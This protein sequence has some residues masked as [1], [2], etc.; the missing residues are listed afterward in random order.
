MKKILLVIIF[1]IL[2]FSIVSAERGR[3]Q[4]VNNNLVAD[5]GWFLRGENSW[6]TSSERNNNSFWDI[7]RDEFNMNIIRVIVYREPQNWGCN[8]DC[9]VYLDCTLD[10]TKSV[11]CGHNCQCP[12]Y[13][14]RC[15]EGSAYDVNCLYT[16]FTNV[17]SASDF[18]INPKDGQLTGTEYTR[19]LNFMNTE[20]IPYLDD[21]VEMS[22]QKNFYLMIDYHP[23]GGNDPMDV[24]LF[25]ELIAPRYKDRTHV[26]Y[27]LM[28]EPSILFTDNYN[29]ANNIG[30]VDLEVEL[31]NLARSLAPETHLI[32]WTFSHVKTASAKPTI[33][34]APEIDYSKASVG[35]HI[36]GLKEIYLDPIKA[37]Y[38]VFQTE[39]GATLGIDEYNQRIALMESKGL[40]WITLD[41]TKYNPPIDVT[42]SGDPFFTGGT[43]TPT[44]S[45]GLISS[46]CLCGGTSY[47]SGY[48]CS[49]IWQ[50]SACSISTEDL[51]SH[52]KL[53]ET[54]GTTADDFIGNNDGTLM[55]NP[56][57]LWTTGKFG[58]AL[59]F[60]GVDDYVELGNSASLKPS[61]LTVS[62][63]VYLDSTVTDSYPKII[64]GN[65]DNYGYQLFYN[66][67]G[68]AGF[69]F[70]TGTGLIGKGIP[71]N[72]TTQNQWVHV[73]GVHDAS[74][75]K[76]Y[77]NGV[78]IGTIPA[79]EI[80]YSAITTMRLGNRG[81]DARHWKGMIDDVRIYNYALTATEILNLYNEA[82]FSNCGLS[83]SNRDGVVNIS[84]LMNYISQWKA[85]TV[86]IGNLM[87]AIGEWKNGCH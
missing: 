34:S 15:N 36:Y 9:D 49:N 40:S 41:G 74:S 52:W 12:G 8:G 83:D 32:L 62:A 24:K 76:I 19:W 69:T 29:N 44:C 25:W 87:I 75:N 77:V 65:N 31:F 6:L 11:G 3:V 26:I 28:N 39:I 80:D 61:L 14:Q 81:N 37:V 47:S 27:E 67:I 42:W 23:V 72:I 71:S 10:P 7:L 70:S 13:Y 86:L 73:V 84:E 21:W 17:A 55:N 46:T 38:P 85:G 5:N 43:I 22:S 66:A 53:D 63:W 57:P 18:D 35:F 64:D 50:S 1:A 16:K 30:L 45:E 54:S 4:H 60:D 48:C 82:S 59:S 2:L 79:S 68:G 78:L 58:N 20:I 51:I 33:D 56:T